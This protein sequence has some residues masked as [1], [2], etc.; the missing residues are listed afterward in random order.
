MKFLCTRLC[1]KPNFINQNSY[2][3]NLSFDDEIWL[4]S[5]YQS[6]FKQHF[7][8]CYGCDIIEI[9][10]DISH[11]LQPKHENSFMVLNT[12]T[13]PCVLAVDEKDYDDWISETGYEPIQLVYEKS[14]LIFLGYDVMD[15]LFISIKSHGYIDNLEQYLNKFG[16]FDNVESAYYFLVKNQIF[17]PEHIWRIVGIYSSI[18][19]NNF[20]TESH[21]LYEPLK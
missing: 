9:Y 17:I 18:H 5:Y 14:Q 3:L 20:F 10:N 16:L 21:D 12:D 7:F 8:D 1:R 6:Y 13:I 2:K 15:S 19:I 4:Y 11:I